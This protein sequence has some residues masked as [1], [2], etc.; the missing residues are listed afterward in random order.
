[1]DAPVSSESADRGGEAK[2]GD[3]HSWHHFMADLSVLTD[4]TAQNLDRYHLFQVVLLCV[5]YIYIYVCMITVYIYIYVYVYIYIAYS[6][7][8][9]SVHAHKHAQTH[10]QYLRDP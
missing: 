2:K 10:R 4:M 6:R 9:L 3:H 7:S 1:M 8:A 5:Y